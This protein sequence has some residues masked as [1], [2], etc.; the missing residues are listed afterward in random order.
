VSPSGLG[1]AD[2]ASPA[3]EKAG[4][5][6]PP[7][8]DRAGSPLGE[9]AEAE[10]PRAAFERRL[11]REILVAERLRA[12]FLALV[13]G[14]GLL[15]FLAITS[16][17]PE[18]VTTLLRG[19]FDRVPVGL[20]L[21]AVSIFEL[22]VLYYTERMLRLGTAPSASLRYLFVFIETSL[23]TAVIAYYGSIFGPVAALLMPTSFLYFI[24]ILLSTLR[25][26]FWLS[27]F[28]GLVAG[29]EYA[30]LATFWGS[31]DTGVA[32]PVLS[33]L[34]QHLAKAFI[35]LVTGISAGFVASQLRR[36]FT[37]AIRSVEERARILG[38]FRQH[39]SPE[40]VEQ[41]VAKEESASSDLRDVCV[42]F[43]DIRGFTSFAEKRSAE[44]VVAYLN[45]IF[46][47]GVDAIVSHHGIVNKFLGDGFMAV[48]GA[49]TAGRNPCADAVDAGLEVL[50]RI[51][52]LVADGRIPATRVGL[53][54]HA[55]PAVVGN[56]GSTTR[57]EYTVIGD[58]VNLASRLEAVNKELG[59]Q[60]LVTEEVWRASGRTEGARAR[61]P[62]RVRGRET[63]VRIFQLA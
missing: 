47:E 8:L 37:S 10:D 60:M 45:T 54:L 58:V 2:A 51:D 34:Q 50:A 23:P 16:A 35:L 27:T 24:F 5:A 56:I 18:V 14:T 44:E 42:M 12:L 7:V 20:F 9:P 19:E 46:D 17:Y 1:P 28:T 31:T 30:A 39:V 38:V 32:E 22:G 25:L 43:L 29:L 21:C 62:I 11:R 53:G 57:K 55:G 49:P 59:S 63:P 33:S 40:V 52:A 6:S 36:S 13:P 4:T 61:E 3:L 26:D 15:A 41:L 48:F